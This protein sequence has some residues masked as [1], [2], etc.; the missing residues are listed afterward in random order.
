MKSIDKI[1]SI[2]LDYKKPMKFNEW[3]NTHKNSFTG[4]RIEMKV[5]YDRMMKHSK[6]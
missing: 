1:Q 6:S 4:N 3:Y 5:V 2:I